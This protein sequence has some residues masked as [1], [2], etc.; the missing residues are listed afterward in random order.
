MTEQRETLSAMMDGEASEIEI[1]RVLRQMGDDQSLKETWLSWHQVRSVVQGGKDSHHM[2]LRTHMDLHARI[3]AAV[4]EESAPVGKPINTPSSRIG[5]AR[6]AA[7]LAMAASLVVAVFV[8]MQIQSM[9]TA[10]STGE[11]ATQPIAPTTAVQPQYVTNQPGP[12]LAAPVREQ[13]EIESD[14]RELDEEGQRRLRAYLQQHDQL[15]MNNDTQYVTY[16]DRN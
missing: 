16:P 12:Q 8:G 9:N 5:F 13:S 10:D 1:H 6:P 3:S 7:G 11:V 14:L 2:P 4:A 15:R